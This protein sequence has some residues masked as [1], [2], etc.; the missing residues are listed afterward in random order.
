MPGN[1]LP[2]DVEV[3]SKRLGLGIPELFERFLVVKI[4]WGDKKKNP[5]FGFSPVVADLKGQRY[6]SNIITP[7]YLSACK[8]GDFACVFIEYSD[9]EDIYKCGI[10]DFKPNGCFNLRCRKMTEGDNIRKTSSY[11]G[12]SWRKNYEVFD[13]LFPKLNKT[14]R[15]FKGE[16]NE[17]NIAVFFA[18]KISPIFLGKKYQQLSFFSK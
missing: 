5:S 13:I 15:K 4:F 10:H 1:L 6:Q 2:G 3:M 11:Y 7:S 8:S 16:I 17:E 14:M 18:K 12:E 9:K